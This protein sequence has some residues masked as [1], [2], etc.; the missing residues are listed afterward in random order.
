MEKQQSFVIENLFRGSIINH[1]SFLM[2]DGMDTDAHCK[3]NVHC[4]AIS[5]EK[6]NYLREKYQELDEALDK[7][8]RHLVSGDRREPAID[9]II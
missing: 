3:T 4:F 8:E 5:I 2:N 1:N 6:V 9:Y 7:A